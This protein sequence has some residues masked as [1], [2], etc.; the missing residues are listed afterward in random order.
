MS[1]KST[2]RLNMS[3]FKGRFVFLSSGDENGFNYIKNVLG[4]GGCNT[5]PD[6]LVE[7]ECGATVATNTLLLNCPACGRL[8]TAKESESFSDWCV[9]HP[10]GSSFGG[11]MRPGCEFINRA[12][13]HFR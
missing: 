7:C 4:H 8:V 2:E 11:G 5:F 12:A 9:A 6:K 13:K 3:T 10:D 1:Y